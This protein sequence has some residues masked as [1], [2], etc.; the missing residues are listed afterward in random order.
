[1]PTLQRLTLVAAALALCLA[2]PAPAQTV[3]G[4]SGT[5]E[6]KGRP[7]ANRLQSVFTVNIRQRGNKVSGQFFVS[8]FNAEADEVESEAVVTPFAGTVS[9]DLV[10]IEFDPRAEYGLGE[11]NPVYRRP[12]GR[13]P[14]LATLRLKAGSL[15]WSLTR[16]DKLAE[17]I[18]RQLTMRRAEHQIQG[19]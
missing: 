13:A 12:K 5:W 4:L 18:P 19:G 17:D 9:G 15:E 10:T 16:G 6:W 3:R 1:M 8:V 7:D 14:S 2:A 11:G